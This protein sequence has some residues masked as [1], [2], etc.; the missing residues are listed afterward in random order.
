[1][2]HLLS[3]A[4]CCALVT[5][6]LLVCPLLGGT[7]AA[8]LPL[9]RIAH[10]AFSE[11]IAI[12]WVGAEQGIFRKHGVNVE[13]INI[14]SGPQTIGRAGFRRYSSGVHDPWFRG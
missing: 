6:F 7:N 11:K 13:V 12:M 3:A 2:K 1:M 9:V 8:E 4:H 14:R 5:A 10:G